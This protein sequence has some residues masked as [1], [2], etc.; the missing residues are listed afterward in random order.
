M[1]SQQSAIAEK[2][3]LMA[4][5]KE[6]ALQMS[7]EVCD[8]GHHKLVWGEGSLV[9]EVAFVGEAPGDKEEAAGRPFVGQAGKLLDSELIAP[10]ARHAPRESTT[11]GT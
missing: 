11:A 3:S 5:L 2:E 4:D 9:A 8:T 6:R 1:E 7:P 10:T